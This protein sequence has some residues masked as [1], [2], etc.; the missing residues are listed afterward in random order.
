MNQTDDQHSKVR[1]ANFSD[2]VL[3]AENLLDFDSEE[4]D[5]TVRKIRRYSD[6]PYIYIV[7][8]ESANH[9]GLVL[10]ALKTIRSPC[11]PYA[12]FLVDGAEIDCDDTD[13]DLVNVEGQDPE[14]I[15]NSILAYVSARFH[16]D[17]TMLQAGAPGP[18]PR[19]VDVVIVGAGITGLYAADR[20]SKAGISTVVLEKREKVGGIWSMYANRTSQ[21]NSSECAYRLIEKRSRSNRDHSATWE[22]L[23]DIAELS[24]RISNSFFLKTEVRGIEKTEKGYRATLSRGKEETVLESKGIILAINDRVGPPREAR[25][26]NHSVFQ[27]SIVNGISDDTRGIDWR[28]KKVVIVGMGA[29]AVENA[30]TALTGGAEHVTVVCR[31]HGTVCPKIIDYLNF[32]TPYNDAFQHDNKSNLRNMSYWKKLY[33]LS[34]AT[35]PE[36]W[37]GMIKHEGHTISVSDIWFIAHFLKKIETVTGEIRAITQKD[38]VTDSGHHIDADIVVN[39]IG[40]ERNAAMAEELSGCSETYNTNYLNKDFMYLADAFIDSNAFNSL[41]GSSVLEMVKFYTEIFIKFF[42]TPEFERMIDCEG[43]KKIPIGRRRWSDYI[44]GAMALIRHYPDVHKMAHEQVAQRTKNF[45]EIHDLETYI[46]ANIREWIDTHSLL[47][48][49]PMKENECLPYVF[50]KLLQK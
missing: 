46:E 36:C 13:L 21:V 24:G 40:F 23:K 4:T 25:W 22:I 14:A 49:R 48:G 37:M 5:V 42:D 12:L 44:D 41:F 1:I 50:K 7:G 2:I 19:E 18:L 34:G 35:Q 20:L 47:A 9:A 16:V 43:I 10:S 30:R 15:A 45:Y 38:V 8:K 32:S 27:G 3:K 33:T 29:F 17:E 26:E 31:R 39:C 11:Y 28:A 6:L